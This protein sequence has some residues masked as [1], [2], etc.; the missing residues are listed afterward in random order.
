MPPLPTISGVHRVAFNWRAGASGPYA[1]N[2]MHF[3]G[4]STDT[5][6]L[7][8]AL[9]ANVTTAMWA[10]C[11]VATNVYQLQITPLD[12]SSSTMIYTVTGTKWAG[13]AGSTGLIPAAC[14]IVSLKT[15]TRGRRSR[16]RVYLPFTDEGNVS[17]GSLDSAPTAAQ[18]AWDTFRTAMTTSLYPMVVASY[19]HGYHKTGGKGQ[20][21][22]Y[23][24]YTWTADSYVVTSSTVE[25]VL[26]TQRK[27]QSRLRV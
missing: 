5:L 12:G 3:K 8:N 18:A 9:D 13:P 6:A 11:G 26:G 4:A 22:V 21:I 17:A 24:P 23:T 20:P 15:A 27:R 19:G 2:V 1:T 16:G 25:R 7:K 10:G 14:V